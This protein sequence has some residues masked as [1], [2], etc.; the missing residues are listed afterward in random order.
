LRSLLQAGAVCL[1]VG[2]NVGVVSLAASRWVGP[3]GHV[4]AFEPSGR[5]FARLSA[6]IERSQLRNVTPIRAALSSFSGSAPLRV[7]AAASG[8]LNTLGDSFPYEGVEVEQIEEVAVMTLDDFV[9][10]HGLPAVAVIK[11]DIEG[12]EGEAITGAAR[13]LARD[14]PAL[15]LEVFERTLRST[16]WSVARLEELITGA[17]FLLFEI[18]DRTAELRS[19]ASLSGHNEQNLVALP[20][21]RSRDILSRAGASII[22]RPSRDL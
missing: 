12:S 14:R 21:E 9:E 20:K 3:S 2:A 22:D 15:V 6:N 4:Y 5:E 11:L 19:V 7:A 17:G 16:G 10:R 18:D 8:G 13:L 1:D